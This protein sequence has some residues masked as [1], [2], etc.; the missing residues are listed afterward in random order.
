MLIKYSGNV[1]LQNTASLSLSPSAKAEVLTEEGPT[2]EPV[3]AGWLT[4][5]GC[6]FLLR[7]EAKARL[8]DK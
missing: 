3:T 8:Y 1:C 6:G 7:F 2:D 5:A 4:G